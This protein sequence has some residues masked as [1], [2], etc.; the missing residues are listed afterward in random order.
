MLSEAVRSGR[1]AADR[2]GVLA[3]TILCIRH[4]CIATGPEAEVGGAVVQLAENYV[5][6]ATGRQGARQARPAQQRPVRPEAR[7]AARAPPRPA[8]RETSERP[9]APPTQQAPPEGR[10]EG[11]GSGDLYA[12]L[13]EALAAEAKVDR[14]LAGEVIAKVL[15]YLSVY[16]S[17][18]VIRLLEDLS[19]GGKVD[20]RLLKTA[21]DVLRSS[22]VVEIKDVGV[23]N[24]KRQVG[25]RYIPL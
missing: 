15:E 21:L 8:T 14:G 1:V 3:R 20:A 19:R 25:G 9:A 22:D 18:G 5:P 24:L 10:D 11:G 6:Q 16:H 13:V 23:V 2:L 12:R 7:Q 17:V 4:G